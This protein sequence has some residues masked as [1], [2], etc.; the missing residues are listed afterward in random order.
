VRAPNVGLVLVPGVDP[1]LPAAWDFGPD[2]AETAAS[3]GASTR[4]FGNIGWDVD[5]FSRIF[6]ALLGLGLGLRSVLT[7]RSTGWIGALRALPISPAQAAWARIVGGCVCVAI[8]ALAWWILMWST[9]LVIGLPSDVPP[10][11]WT[12]A[13][14][15]L[16]SM[17]TF[18][19]LGSICAWRFT[20][21]SQAILAGLSVWLL[22]AVLGPTV[23]A[24]GA[25]LG[26]PVAPQ[27]RMERERREQYS[28]GI[29]EAENAIADR[30]SASLPA[31]VGAAAADELA[32]ASFSLFE[33]EWQRRAQIAKAD[34]R[35][36]ED[37]WQRD[38]SAQSRLAGAIAFLSP[39][40]LLHDTLAELA[41]T[42]RGSDDHWRDAISSHARALDVA[43]FDNRP[44]INL[45]VAVNGK[46]VLMNFRRHE[47]PRFSELPA[48]EQPASSEA[49]RIQ[50]AAPEFLGLIIWLTGTLGGSYLLGVRA[51]RN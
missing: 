8:G 12:L 10:R 51:L 42:G 11:L 25:E 36:L 3:F 31:N 34:S 47:A 30:I 18:F 35:E 41:D 24:L 2:G 17:W 37:Q 15:T 13:V 44:Q 22:L 38:L 23:A 49:S 27:L 40:A 4:L 32:T 5:A 45:R 50:A 14:P 16:I 29:R 28:D 19:G 6:G 1:L 9:A 7:D 43:L 20:T 33:P 39:G 46:P 21:E 26:R 48:F